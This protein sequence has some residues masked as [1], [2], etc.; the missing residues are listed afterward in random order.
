MVDSLVGEQLNGGCVGIASRSVR[1][2]IL[3][4]TLTEHM[5]SLQWPCVE[6]RRKK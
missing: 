5:Q 6:K 4:Y 2:H 3:N 1:D